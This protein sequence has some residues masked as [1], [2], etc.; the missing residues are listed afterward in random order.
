MQLIARAGDLDRQLAEIQRAVEAHPDEKQFLQQ[1]ER[2]Y[3]RMG[4]TLDALQTL[5]RMIEDE[6]E[7]E[8]LK[9]RLM[10]SWMALRNPIKALE[11]KK[12]LE[13]EKKKDKAPPEDEPERAKRWVT[14]RDV[15]EAVE[16][17]DFEAAQ[18]AY[19]RMWRT[20]P[21]G[22]GNRY[23]RVY[24]G[25]PRAFAWPRDVDE[26]DDAKARAK[27]RARG[28]L[29]LFD[30]E[31][32]T[33]VERQSAYDVLATFD[34]GEA[35]LRRQVRIWNAWQM[36]SGGPVVGGL[37]QAMTR[38]LGKEGARDVLMGAVEKGRAGKLEYAM[39]LVLL[40][41]D[42]SLVSDEALAILG[43]LSRTLKPTDVAQIRKL[44]KVWARLGGQAE[45][46][47]LYRWC[48]AQGGSNR[49]GGMIMVGPGT[50]M[51]TSSGGAG[52][53]LVKEVGDEIDGELK[54]ETIERILA[55]SDP[56]F[57]QGNS[58]TMRDPY[59][60]LV[61]ETWIEVLGPDEALARCRDICAEVGDTSKGLRRSAARTA[62][63]LLARAGEHEAALDA[64]EVALCKL[65]PPAGTPRWYQSWYRNPGALSQGTIQTIVPNT[66]VHLTASGDVDD[67]GVT[68]V[69]LT[70]Q[71]SSG[72]L[73]PWTVKAFSGVDGS[74][75]LSIEGEPY[76]ALGRQVACADL[77]GDG[78]HD[79]IASS[80]YGL[81]TQ[82]DHPILRAYS[83]SDG[84][85]MWSVP[86]IPSS[87]GL[88][89]DRL[90][91]GFF[92]GDALPDLALTVGVTT[93]I[94]EVHLIRGIDGS[95]IT[96]LLDN[97]TILSGCVGTG[98]F[99]G[100]SYTDLVV[101]DRYAGETVRVLSGSDQ[102][103]IATFPWPRP[104]ENSPVELPVVLGD[105]NGDTIDDLGFSHSHYDGTFANMGRAWAISGSDG[106]TLHMYEGSID[107]E[108]VGQ[109]LQAVGDVDD[110]GHADFAYSSGSWFGGTTGAAHVMSGAT[111]SELFRRDNWW[112]DSGFS[113]LPWQGDLDG[114]GR[115]EVLLSTVDLGQANPDE[116]TELHFVKFGEPNSIHRIGTAYEPRRPVTIGYRSTRDRVLGSTMQVSLRGGN[117]TSYTATLLVGTPTS[118]PL[119]AIGLVGGTL[120]VS[121]FLT[122]TTTPVFADADV[123]I[124]LPADPGLDGLSFE[125]QWVWHEVWAPN[126]LRLMV[127]E[128]MRVPLR[129]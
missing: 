34:F 107:Y 13:A 118:V 58:P 91:T 20:F 36:A 66:Q 87:I 109:R 104:Q 129:L 32:P 56:G 10:A 71:S 4:R 16:E 127:G 59:E 114:D 38:R 19:R 86:W 112:F 22:S 99:D 124:D 126:P 35:E 88:D 122:I 116:I 98:D 74:E 95:I 75:L 1:L 119:D 120:Y 27:A 117:A 52:S 17:R 2:Q 54:I 77:D 64:L 51:S 29:A 68:D 5:E 62:A 3:R 57:D 85:L 110:D 46:S 79:V 115:G 24:Y 31:D 81:T 60:T 39:L 67:D 69:V 82:T 50:W 123:T 44:A 7:D 40:Q 102:S 90:H 61:L 70:Q 106:A 97:T 84:S 30:D 121:P 80:M 41:E 14:A 65:E 101:A 21:V 73:V 100:D 48:A 111:G 93:A 8:G 23:G 96:T 103:T 26:S 94:T 42:T 125:M 49:G 89:P 108:Q 33:P 72:I 6:P 113:A 105:V 83:G 63:W 15:K 18:T 12:E 25:G 11:L 37:V 45:A 78:H 92:D 55:L 53:G 43:D 28:G 128:A 47:R 9:N 76:K